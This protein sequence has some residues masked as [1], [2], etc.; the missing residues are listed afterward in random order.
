LGIWR[1]PFDTCDSMAAY[2]ISRSGLMTSG[3]CTAAYWEWSDTGRMGA[4]GW[5]MNMRHA[6]VGLTI[7][8]GIQARKFGHRTFGHTSIR[9]RCRRLVVL[10]PLVSRECICPVVGHHLTFSR[11][12]V[13]A[14]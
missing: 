3:R 11:Y 8:E 13:K 1:G 2:G 7:S 6:M 10:T 14:A 9:V 4:N 12:L 5:R